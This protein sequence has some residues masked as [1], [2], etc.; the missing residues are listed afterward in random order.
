MTE[1]IKLNSNFRIEVDI[2]EKDA[3]CEVHFCN[4]GGYY[5]CEE[6]VGVNVDEAKQ[7]IAALTKFV[8]TKERK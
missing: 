2:Y 3:Y 6:Y 4:G 5:S 1:T 7:I 8:E